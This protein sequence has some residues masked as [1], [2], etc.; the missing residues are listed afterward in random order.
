M[1][2]LV[3]SLWCALGTTACTQSTATTPETEQGTAADDTAT[4]ARDDADLAAAE[5]TLDDP[6]VV[7]DDESTTEH[8]ASLGYESPAP[9]P[10]T[11]LPGGHDPGGPGY[12]WGGGWCA[13]PQYAPYCGARDPD[14]YRAQREAHQREYDRIREENRRHR[15]GDQ[16]H[17]EVHREYPGG[18]QVAPDADRVPSTVHKP[19]HG[20]GPLDDKARCQDACWEQFL[21]DTSY[22]RRIPDKIKRQQCWIKS[23]EDYGLCIRECSRKYPGK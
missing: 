11:I 5:R 10:G 20:D 2:A 13:D 22:C 15:G 8:A 6:A 18:K 14:P 4:E 16:G 21:I 9:G 7:A 23:E 1:A 17:G 3:L 19:H 12:G